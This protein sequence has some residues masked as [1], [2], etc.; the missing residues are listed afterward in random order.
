MERRRFMEVVGA[1]SAAAALGG[2][3]GCS[4]DDEPGADSGRLHT[5][6]RARGGGGLVLTAAA[7]LIRG[8]LR[9]REGDPEGCQPV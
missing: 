2:L 7:P 8:L 3:V 4:D 1:A 6:E 9:G 5:G